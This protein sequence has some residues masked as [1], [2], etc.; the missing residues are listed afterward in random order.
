M[1]DIVKIIQ[2]TYDC[3][4]T[5]DHLVFSNADLNRSSSHI[6]DL[7]EIRHS[8]SYYVAHYNRIFLNDYNFNNYNNKHETFANMMNSVR[9]FVK[10]IEYQDKPIDSNILPWLNLTTDLPSGVLLRQQSHI[11]DNMLIVRSIKFNSG[12]NNGMLIKTH[13]FSVLQ[14]ITEYQAL[15]PIIHETIHRHDDIS[16]DIEFYDLPVKLYADFIILKYG[17]E[18]G[19]ITYIAEKNKI[20]YY[21]GDQSDTV[22]F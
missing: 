6:V 20:T 15:L 14:M 5:N 19:Y 1:P 13:K 17:I 4:V 2:R 9:D 7:K 10:A 16:F 21:F 11:S 3:K 8:R 12:S 22:E 18:H